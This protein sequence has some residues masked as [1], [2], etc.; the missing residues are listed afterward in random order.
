[1]FGARAWP[2]LPAVAR[3]VATTLVAQDLPKIEG[4]SLAGHQVTL[5][6]IEMPG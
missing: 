5:L 4:D 3:A 6:S 2:W 1:M